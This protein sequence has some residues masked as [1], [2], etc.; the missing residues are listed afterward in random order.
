MDKSKLTPALRQFMEAKE[1]YPDHIL[2]FRMGDFYEMF[3]DDAVTAAGVLGIALTKRGKGTMGEAPMCGVPHHAYETY[4]TKLLK[5]G[6]KVAV[7]EQVE[8]PKQAKGVVKRAVTAVLTP[9]TAH[10][11]AEEETR[12]RRLLALYVD[13]K[14]AG[15]AVGDPT[16]GECRLAE[17]SGPRMM[18]QLQSQVFLYEPREIISPYGVLTTAMLDAFKHFQPIITELEEASF[19][20]HAASERIKELFGVTTV[21]GFGLKG[22]NTALGALAGWFHYLEDNY[23]TDRFALRKIRFMQPEGQLV[24]D[25][26]TRRNLDLFIAQNTG[27]YR[28]SFCWAIDRTRTPMGNRKLAEWV[29]FPSARQDIIEQ[30]LDVVAWFT[31]NSMV[32]EDIRDLLKHIPDMERILTRVAL[33]TVPPTDLTALKHAVAAAPPVRD[34]LGDPVFDAIRSG[35][36][37]LDD[38]F[39]ELD[40]TLEEEAPRVKG[41]GMIRQG[42]DGELDELRDILANVKSALKQLELQEQQRT[43]INSLKVKYNKVF[44]YYIEISK[45]N[46]RNGVPDNYERKQTLVNAERFITPELKTFEE[47]VLTAEER[48]LAIEHR[49]FAELV[50]TVAR[51]ATSLFDLADAYAMLDVLSGFSALALERDFRRPELTPDNCICIEQGRHP[52]V[53][54]FEGDA[55]VPN[56]TQLDEDRRLAIITGPNM[57]GKSTY[58]RQ[59]ALIVLLAHMGSFVPARKA[60][61]GLTDRIFTRVGSSDNLVGGESTFMV[62]MIETA[63]ILHNATER[64]VVVLDEVGRGT[65]T[66]DGLSLAWAITEH[67]AAF[68]KD[69]PRTFFA[70]HYHELTDIDHLFDNIVNLNVVVREWNNEL[71]FLRKIVPGAADQSYGI[72]VARLA[73]IP[74][75]V[76]NRAFQVLENI[77]KNEFNLNGKPKL[78]G[79]ALEKPEDRPLWE[80]ADHPVL[81]E[82]K[83]LNV[84]TL[85]P[86]EAL[87]LLAKLKKGV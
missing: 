80:S 28:G 17:F 65:A 79:H 64:S 16:T 2:F 72:Q 45:V 22:R 5:A 24:V 23:K 49:I 33:G 21:A 78:A 32:L 35:I 73:G 31:E 27:K 61:I 54:V 1:A 37:D 30:R 63:N 86:L 52:V 55:F 18:E 58:L 57:G 41:A 8:D 42:V 13:G 85:T 68:K 26:I 51:Y 66:F 20:H 34:Q 77:Q 53:E 87:N 10:L 81:L 74:K 46:L 60:I 50:Q 83:G 38:L 67:L 25:P 82:L 62:E 69:C 9:A 76:I 36:H 6:F 12:S 43:G 39:I 7:C 75:P 11:V 59:N 48:I 70:T 71:L 19:S 40:R 15:I 4:A 14:K 84:E 44:G 56:D 47:K 29:Q 3:F